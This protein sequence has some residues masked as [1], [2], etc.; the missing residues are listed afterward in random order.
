MQPEA[1]GTSWGPTQTWKNAL[2]EEDHPT[3][4]IADRAVAWLGKVEEPFFAW[5]SFPDP[6]HP[7]DPPHPWCD[8]YRPDDM[9]AVLPKAHPA[10][11]E[12]KPAFH[13]QWS[14]GFRGTPYEWANPGW[15]LFTDEERRTI[16]AAYYGMIAQL[17]H[18]VGRVLDVLAARGLADQTLV[19][20]TADHGDY[21]GDHQLMLKGPIHYEALIRV[22]LI[23]RGPGM[24]PGAVVTDPVGTIDVAPTVLRACGLPMP[25]TIQGRPLDDGSREWAL[26][27]DDMIRGALAFRTLTTPRYRLTRAEHDAA[28]GEL[29][30]LGDDP[31]ELVNR[32]AD[33]G[34][35]RVRADLLA[36]LD[37]VMRHDLGRDLP[38]VCQA[39]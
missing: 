22:P 20:F 37:G 3:S 10:E 30:D 39:G 11:L 24:T 18:A 4:W 29:Y 16:L 31:G 6:H 25:A 13:R 34:M 2:P 8:R 26:T 36:L 15:A 27:E 7:F 14:Q 12:G 38:L 35:R 32:W 33:P 9:A 1:A 23:V 21:M 17:D 19:V 28:D 5:I